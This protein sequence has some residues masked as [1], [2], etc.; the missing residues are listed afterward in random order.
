MTLEDENNR[1]RVENNRR[2][3]MIDRINIEKSE[4]EMKQKEY[5]LLLESIQ[6]EN[7]G[8]NFELEKILEN[9]RVLDN[10]HR[11]IQDDYKNKI[12]DVN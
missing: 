5:E 4:A 12:E 8:K 11:K 1:V 6:V 7:K 2:I 9:Q 10:K 3:T